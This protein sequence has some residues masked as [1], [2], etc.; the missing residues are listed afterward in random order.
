[1]IRMVQSTSAGHAKAYFSE[2]LVKADYYI[3]DQELQGRFNGLVAARLGLGS[4]ATK[5]AFFDLSENLKPGTEHPLTP[6]TA[7]NRTVGYDINFHCPKSVSIVHALSKDDRILKAFERCVTD[8]M[9]EIEAD[10]LTRVRRDGQYEDRQTGELVWT[11]FTHQTARPVEDVPPDPH[12]HSHCFVFN[13]TWDEKEKRFKAGQFRDIKRDMPYYEARFHKRLSDEMMLLGHNIRKT[14]KS[15]EIDGVPQKVI[16][17]FSKRTDEIGRVAKAKGIT[18]AKG[19][20][21]LGA[22]TRSKKQKGY[23]MAELRNNWREQIRQLGVEDG[24]DRKVIRHARVGEHPT[25]EASACVDHALNHSFERASVMHD[26]RLLEVAYKFSIG[27]PTVGLDQIT[28]WFKND[29][30]IIRVKE[31]NKIMC[32][33]HGAFNEEKR[34]VELARAGQ[35][36]MKPLYYEAPELKLKGQQAAAVS[37]ILTTPHQVSIIKGGAGTGKTKLTREAV[38]HIE[39]KGKT[40]TMLAPSS[41]AAHGVLFKEGFKNADTVARF[42]LD[43]KMQE[44]T[45]DQVIWVDEAG[46]LGVKDTMNLLEIAKNNNARV[47]FAGDTRQHTSVVRGDA[48]R[49]LSTVGGIRSAEVNKIYRQRNEQ[50][51]AAVEDLL[52]GKIKDGFNKLDEMGAIKEIDPLKANDALVDDYIEAIKAKK[53]TLIV[54]P[55]HAQNEALTKEIRT[56]LKQSKLIGKKEINAFRF[57][58]LNLTEAEK[59]DWK[60]YRKDQIVQFNQNTQVIKRGSLWKVNDIENGTVKIINDKKEIHSLPLNK[61]EAFSLFEKSEIA[62]AKGDKVRITR[63]GFDQKNKRLNNGKMLEVFSVSKKGIIK[64]TSNLGKNIY[65]ISK[66]YGHIAHAH[67]IT[68][69]ASQ[70]ISVDQVFISQPASTFP[71]T[72]AKQFYVSV[73]RG[74]DAVTIYTDDKISLLSHASEMG[75]RESAIELVQRGKSNDLHLAHILNKERLNQPILEKSPDLPKNMNLNIDY[76][77]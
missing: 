66:E 17:L 15:F 12:L 71:A 8:T 40:V 44:A 13:A 69:H 9:K 77:I 43:R 24:D 46:L 14:K 19:L 63:N 37:H 36:K 27:N 28:E 50:Y 56:R 30:R 3:N 16:D 70:G 35:G 23:S 33:T 60:N 74:R 18:D 67:C 21:E 47:I 53:E 32:T 22:K 42:L 26:R 73:S 10:S 25:L 64:L 76:E 54:S 59:R 38:E 31:Y 61:S 51:K 65:S 48:L 6:R 52:H 20:D 49:I 75:D 2:A 34:M 11:E 5:E 72:D 57:I 62:L 45:K 39:A 68:S 29:R 7:E 4:K 41:D 55:T 58:N 1:M